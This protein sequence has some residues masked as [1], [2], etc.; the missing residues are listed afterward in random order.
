MCYYR[1]DYLVDLT[2]QGMFFDGAR[3][4]VDGRRGGFGFEFVVELDLEFVV[5]LDLE[6]VIEFDLEFEF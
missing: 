1:S 6:F 3:L 5:E 4:R 2:S